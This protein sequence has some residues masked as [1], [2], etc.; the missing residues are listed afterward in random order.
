MV[1]LL[2]RM[3]LTAIV[4]AFCAV[5]AGAQGYTG[6]VTVGSASGAPGEQVVIP[7]NLSGNNAPIMALTVPLK[8]AGT[9]L[10]V[11]SVSV[12]GSLMEP[13]MSPIIAIDNSARIVKFTYVPIWGNPMITAS[14]GLLAR[15]FFSISPSAVQHTVAIDSINAI[16][17]AGPP[18]VRVRPEFV[19]TTGVNLLQ[20]G[21]AA[22]S[23]QIQESMDAGDEDVFVPCVLALNQNFPN[24]F[25]PSTIISFT[26]PQRTQVRLTIFNI[27]G[28]QVALLADNLMEA[29]E[30]QISWKASTEA[31]GLYFYRL[32]VGD[33]VLT[34]K[35]TLLK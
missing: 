10:E 20:P 7:V 15:I 18:T 14:S 23:V 9:D 35:M 32:Q 6:T 34:R 21:F 2:T 1:Q 11:D 17:Y 3:T 12:V 16:A 8:F 4:F 33:Q 28:Q 29:G 30:H 25:N 22:G 13:N 5:T 19:D 27:L 31:S 26:L 24:P